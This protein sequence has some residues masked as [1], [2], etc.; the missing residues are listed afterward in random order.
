MSSDKIVIKLESSE[1]E[2]L[3]EQCAQVAAVE[4]QYWGDVDDERLALIAIGAMGAAANICVAI[5]IGRTPEQHKA[6]C[7]TRGK[8]VPA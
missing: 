8:D 7:K 5:L 4:A 6:D 3:R 2:Q 1:A